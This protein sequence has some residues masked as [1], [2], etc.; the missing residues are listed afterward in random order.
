M[1][2]HL[3]R[4]L[5]ANNTIY[6]LDYFLIEETSTQYSIEVVKTASSGLAERDSISH[7][8]ATSCN[9]DA[10][11]NLLADGYVTPV[12]LRDIVLDYIS[13]STYA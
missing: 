12:T 11:I 9:I 13:S 2:V 10:L 7:I 6:R 3:S 8:T 4:N 5:V 1:S